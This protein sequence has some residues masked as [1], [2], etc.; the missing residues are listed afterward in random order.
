MCNSLPRRLCPHL[1]MF[2]HRQ[3]FDTEMQSFFFLFTRYLAEK[4]K[5][6]DLYVYTFLLLEAL[7]ILN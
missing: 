7:S 6:Q 3:A 5:R 2:W 1:V 4:A